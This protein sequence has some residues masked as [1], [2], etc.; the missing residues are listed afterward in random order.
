[1]T[2]RSETA[3]SYEFFANG[4][5]IGTSADGVMENITPEADMTYSVVPSL[6][7]CEGAEAGTSVNVHEPITLALE[8]LQSTVCVN[9]DIELTAT[10]TSGDAATIY[11]NGIAGGN[12]MA[13]TATAN[14]TYEV[15]ATDGVCTSE[16]LTAAINVE[17]SV[18]VDIFP[19][20]EI[21]DGES[22]EIYADISGATSFEWQSRQYGNFAPAGISG[23]TAEVSPAQDTDYKITARGNACPDAEAESSIIVNPLPVFVINDNALMTGTASITIQNGTPPYNIYLNGEDKGG[24]YIWEGLDMGIYYSVEVTDSKQCSTSGGFETP[25]MPIEIPKFFSPNGDGLNDTWKIGNITAYPD[26]AIEIYDRNSRRIALLH[27]DS[28][29]WDGTYN[30]HLMPMADYWYI[31]T[32]PSQKLR[33]TGH[34]TL[35]R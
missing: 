22:A 4:T 14:A 2:A 21:C 23:L 15:Y 3:D 33:V 25:A 30:G 31:I 34:F 27:G 7:G 13:F 32:I 9:S 16:T 1:M 5:S 28:P 29:A 17:D 11:W 24:Q 10:Q 18:R 19:P 6:Q 26:A 8:P 20:L 12:S 35:K